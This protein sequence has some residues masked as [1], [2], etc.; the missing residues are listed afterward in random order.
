MHSWTKAFTVKQSRERQKL[1]ILK[2]KSHHNLLPNGLPNFFIRQSEIVNRET[3]TYADNFYV[4]P[5]RMKITKKSFFYQGPVL[6]NE[7]DVE[8]RN[9]IISSTIQKQ[10]KTRMI[11][12]LYVPDSWWFPCFSCIGC[13]F[14]SKAIRG[15]GV[16]LIDWLELMPR[17]HQ[18]HLYWYV[19]FSTEVIQSIFSGN[20]ISI[21]P[22]LQIHGIRI[23]LHH[24]PVMHSIKWGMNHFY[25]YYMIWCFVPDWLCSSPDGGS[26]GPR[27]SWQTWRWRLSWY[28]LIT[29]WLIRILFIYKRL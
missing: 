2:Y 25:R 16:V 20:L 4:Y 18:Y 13:L 7:S 28:A 12:S 5:P 14:F 8:L 9:V 21:M 1:M 19:R 29:Y 26:R 15:V 24:A 22:G 3:R 17:R 11:A 27:V 6:W 23:S 10:L